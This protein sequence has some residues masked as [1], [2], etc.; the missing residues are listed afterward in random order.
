MAVISDGEVDCQA[1]T[2]ER[3][4]GLIDVDK[5]ILQRHGMSL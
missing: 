3:V 5:Q 2:D 1:Q 4:F